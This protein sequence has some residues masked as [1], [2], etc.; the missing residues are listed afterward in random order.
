M[1]LHL[2]SG[3]TNHKGDTGMKRSWRL[4]A[5][6]GVLGLLALAACSSSSKKS[7]NNT[8]ATTSAAAGTTGGGATTTTTSPPS[9]H[10]ATATPTTG[11]KNGT[12]VA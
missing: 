7:E 10:K 4:T 3:S 6:V 8:T 12:A 5:M 9:P 11:L 1:I 2:R